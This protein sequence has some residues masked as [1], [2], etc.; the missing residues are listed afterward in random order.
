MDL[1]FVPARDRDCWGTLGTQSPLEWTS[2]FRDHDFLDDVTLR[3]FASNSHSG[4]YIFNCWAEAWGKH[5]WFPCEENDAQAKELAVMNGK[6]AEGIFRMN[7]TYPKDGFWWDSQLR[8]TPPFQAGDHFLEG[9]AHAVAEL[10]ALRI[11]R[12]GLFL[13]KAHGDQIRRFALPY[14]SL[15]AKK[16][17]TVGDSTDPVAVRTL[18]CDGKRYVYLV[19]RE[20]YPISVEVQLEKSTGKAT[21]LAT[22]QPIDAPATWQVTLGPYDLR[23]FALPHQSEVKDFKAT[24]PQDIERQLKEEAEGVVA[25]IEKAKKDGKNLPPGAEKLTTKIQAAIKDGRLAWLRRALH[26]YPILKSR[27][28]TK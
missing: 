6:P 16:F 26:S 7:S 9:Y 21:D 28:L 23:S 8:I 24:V 22:G 1:S 20:Y 17:Q 18:V 11:T 2:M 12:G 15:P 10:D 19:N 3:G 4:V 5:S 14:R 25:M 27:Q 13:D